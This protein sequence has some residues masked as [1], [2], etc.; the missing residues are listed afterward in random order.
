MMAKGNEI[1]VSAFCN[2]IPPNHHDK[3]NRSLKIPRELGGYKL[4]DSHQFTAPSAIFSAWL[5][6]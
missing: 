4:S 1:Y 5:R 3:M 2:M 6:Q